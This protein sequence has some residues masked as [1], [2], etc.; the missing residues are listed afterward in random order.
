VAAD[1]A[2]VSIGARAARSLAVPCNWTVAAAFE[3]SFYLRAGDAFV[4]LGDSSI[5]DGP[6]NVRLD[7]ALRPEVGQ[8]VTTRTSELLFDNGC[9]ISLSGARVWRP[10]AWPQPGTPRCLD[11]RGIVDTARQQ[12]PPA[13]LVHALIADDLP[14]DPLLRRGAAG[15]IALRRALS[16]GRAAAPSSLC[17]HGS[18]PP[19]PPNSA[20]PSDGTPPA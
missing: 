10:P 12:A 5:G 15:I 20:A 6:L 16:S 17:M 1:A 2:I 9:A 8:S 13:S 19:Q 11:L 18:R 3:R 14:T 4:C 7:R